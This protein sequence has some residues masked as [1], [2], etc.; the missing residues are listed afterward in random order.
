MPR[1]RIRRTIPVECSLPTVMLSRAREERKLRRIPVTRHES[2]QIVP[3][4]R[5]LLHAQHM[6]DAGLRAVVIGVVHRGLAAEQRHAKEEEKEA[7]AKHKPGAHRNLRILPGKSAP[8][9][10]NFR[11]EDRTAE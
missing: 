2:F 8:V 4:P 5:L 9:S 7:A 10:H 11:W 6:L 3:V 1:T